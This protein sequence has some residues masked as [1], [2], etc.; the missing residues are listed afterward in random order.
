MAD[1]IYKCN[2]GHIKAFP[3]VLRERPTASNYTTNVDKTEGLIDFQWAPSSPGP[4]TS[5]SKTGSIYLQK[6]D[7][8]G[9]VSTVMFNTL[10]YT[11]TNVQLTRSQHSGWLITDPGQTSIGDLVIL[12]EASSPRKQELIYTIFVIPLLNTGSEATDPEYLKNT[13]MAGMPSGSGVQ[14]CFP[15]KRPTDTE[16]PLFAHYVTCFDGYTNHAHTQNVDVFV[17]TVGVPVSQATLNRIT[18]ELAPGVIEL[19]DTI[20]NLYYISPTT[21]GDAA[22]AATA[23][24]A[25]ATAAGAY[26]APGGITS[27][28]VTQFPNIITVTRFSSSIS[29]YGNVNLTRKDSTSAYKCVELDPNEVDTNNNIHIDLKSGKIASSTLDDILAE[30]EVMKQLVDPD[31]QITPAAKENRKYY[32]FT[33]A[34][35]IILGTA[36]GLYLFVFSNDTTNGR[37]IWEI[38][39]SS[40]IAITLLIAAGFGFLSP[41]KDLQEVGGWMALGSV[42]AG[43]LFFLYFFVISPAPTT[44]ECGKAGIALASGAVAARSGTTDANVSQ[45]ASINAAAK[46]KK[47]ADEAANAEKGWPAFFNSWKGKGIQ[48]GITGAIFGLLGFILGNIV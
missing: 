37:N 7:T 18:G 46:A 21:G 19:P 11:I 5:R 1:R 17:S 36:T 14:S 30:R 12:L 31:A 39:L 6:Q 16:H 23:A 41:N 10:P 25:A 24:T 29:N 15:R 47:A 13:N 27:I 45:Q 35:L 48:I 8:A 32:E 20:S 38:V 9:S 40:I 43:F 3:L 44:T 4:T 42:I 22:A 33:L 34:V 2:T 28:S 26:S